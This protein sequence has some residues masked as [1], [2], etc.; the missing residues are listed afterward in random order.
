LYFLLKNRVSFRDKHYAPEIAMATNYFVILRL[1]FRNFR[2]SSIFRPCLP[3]PA[4]QPT[5]NSKEQGL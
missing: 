5:M 1:I 2:Y 4:R 3:I